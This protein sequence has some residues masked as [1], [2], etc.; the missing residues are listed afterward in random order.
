RPMTDRP[1]LDFSFS[2]LKTFALNTYQTSDP[3]CSR[4]APARPSWRKSQI[5]WSRA[6]FEPQLLHINSG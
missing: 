5:A 4:P 6:P 2:G 1:G 3:S